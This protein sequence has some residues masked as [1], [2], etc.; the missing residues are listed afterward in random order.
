MMVHLR[1]WEADKLTGTALFPHR[2][3]Q[4]LFDPANRVGDG[5]Q[6]RRHTA[7]MDRDCLAKRCALLS[8]TSCIPLC[9]LP[10]GIRSGRAGDVFFALRAL[11]QICPTDEIP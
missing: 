3:S 10:P 8:Y 4:G 6:A 1:T 7:K 5:H 11:N 9:D 2:D